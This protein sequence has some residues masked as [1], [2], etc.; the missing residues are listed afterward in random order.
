M[1]R[2]LALV[3]AMSL[4]TLL[5]GCTTPRI[6]LAM[7]I[8]PNVNPDHTGRPSPVAVKVFELSA[9]LSFK[10]SEFW[11]LFDKP[12]EVLGSD[13]V[14]VDEMVLSPS[15]ARKVTYA[16]SRDTRF[17]GIIA[18]FR[19]I[20]RANWRV[21]S[22]IDPEGENVVA[23]ELKD[24]ALVLLPRHVAI[25]WDPEAAVMRFAETEENRSQGEESTAVPAKEMDSGD[26]GNGYLLPP[27]TRI[28]KVRN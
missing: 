25:S 27:P 28:S 11:S 14:A 8:Q 13:L 10:Q 23:V 18:G 12:V 26:K 6:D 24:V 21:V 4:S 17:L 20:D 1:P 2:L 19:Q 3:M 7:A 22:P 5:A 15:E 9:D 16:P